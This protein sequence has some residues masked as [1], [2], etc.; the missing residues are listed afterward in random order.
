MPKSAHKNI[1]TCDTWYTLHATD[2]KWFY[3]YEIMQKFCVSRTGDFFEKIFL[4]Q[5][6]GKQILMTETE[7]DFFIES[8]YRVSK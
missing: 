6:H 2:D 1:M 8:S 5:E 3:F 4:L 7:K